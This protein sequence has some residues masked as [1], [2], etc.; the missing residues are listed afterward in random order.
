MWYRKRVENH[1]LKRLYS[2]TKYSYGAGAYYDERKK[3]YIRYSCND[4]ALRQ[5]MNRRTRR[6]LK[7]NHEDT[8][9]NGQYKKLA[10]YWWTLL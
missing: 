8:V 5:I 3:R 7:K 6:K 1:R 9:Q 2:E 4:K 10:D